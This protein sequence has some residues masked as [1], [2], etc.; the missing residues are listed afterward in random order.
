[1]RSVHEEFLLLL[2]WTIPGVAGTSAPLLV[3]IWLCC[4]TSWRDL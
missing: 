3:T 4:R 2:P 1:M